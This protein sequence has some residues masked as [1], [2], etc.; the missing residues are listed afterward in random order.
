MPPV[1]ESFIFNAFFYANIPVVGIASASLAFVM[2]LL[3]LVNRVYVKRYTNYLE[4]SFY[5]NL[6]VLSL[7]VSNSPNFFFFLG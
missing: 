7:V 2:V 4:L 3:K 1:D 6:L 5:V